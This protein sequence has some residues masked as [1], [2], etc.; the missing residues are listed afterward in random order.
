M[1]RLQGVVKGEDKGG[2]GVPNFQNIKNLCVLNKHT[3]KVFFSWTFPPNTA[4]LHDSVHVFLEAKHNAS[5]GL[6]KSAVLA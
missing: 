6:L 1:I 4:N 3:I 5:R 2:P